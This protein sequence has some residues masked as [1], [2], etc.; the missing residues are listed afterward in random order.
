MYYQIQDVLVE[1]TREECLRDKDTVP[2]TAVLTKEEWAKYRDDF[3]MGIDLDRTQTKIYSTKAEENFD[4][5]TG[6]FR[7][8]DRKDIPGDDFLFSFAL[9]ERGVVFIDESGFALKQI[10]TI[11]ETKKWRYSCLERFL[12]DFLEQIIVDDR[13]LFE[14]LET[15]LSTI[16]EE[17]LNNSEFNSGGRINEIRRDLLEM[18]THY[19]QLIDMGQIFEENENSFFQEEHLRYFRLFNNQAER[20]RNMI[21][22]LQDY[23]VQ[24]RDLYQAQL[25]N[26]QNHIMTILTIVTTIFMPLTLIVG[27]YGMNFRYMPELESPYAYPAVI[28]LCLLIS[29]GSLLYFVKKKWL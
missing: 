9:D 6:T 28:V 14:D 29:V 18:R 7:I 26:K 2:Y 4:S 19:D 17:I 21:V 15:E 25:G 10:Q 3:E 1:C 16:E 22:F 13:T 23:T 5:I 12:Y 24:I 20:R 27:W 11:Q 8:P